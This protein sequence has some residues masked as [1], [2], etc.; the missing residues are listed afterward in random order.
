[1]L[2]DGSVNSIASMFGFSV[3][4]ADSL[5]IVDNMD[6]NQI[7]NISML[8]EILSNYS[9]CIE[10]DRFHGYASE[11]VIHHPKANIVRIQFLIPV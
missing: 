9:S 11:Q 4:I 6:T 8:A 2:Q 1:M 5:S 7:G 10:T 3:D